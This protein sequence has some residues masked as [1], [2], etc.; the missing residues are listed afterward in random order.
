MI[1]Y[2][3]YCRIQDAHQNQ[4]LN[5]S[6]IARTLQLDAKTVAK[7]L[8]EPRYRPRLQAARKERAGICLR[9]LRSPIRS[10]RRSDS[11]R[12]LN[13]SA[14]CPDF[15]WASTGWRCAA[16]SAP[17]LTHDLLRLTPARLGGEAKKEFSQKGVDRPRSRWENRA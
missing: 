13:A 3:T 1:D 15:R 8:A 12:D 17:A 2:A 5:I 9:P 16:I 11:S 4:G 6:Q 14:R 10:S 7:W